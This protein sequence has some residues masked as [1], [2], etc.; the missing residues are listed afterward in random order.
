MGFNI[1]FDLNKVPHFWQTVVA[2]VVGGV[3]IGAS[4][5]MVAKRIDRGNDV[6]KQTQEAVRSIEKKVV[7]I[8]STQ[9][10]IM[11]AMRSQ[12][13]YFEDLE[14][15]IERVDGRLIYYINHNDDMSAEQ[16]LDAFNIGYS[17]GY[18]DGK[19]KE[20]IP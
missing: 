10:E 7:G 13:S 11:S 15:K 20:V 19:K 12:E 9:Q 17:N 6:V 16:I 18:D 2:M 4:G 8:D 14:D 3:F 5:L 1:N